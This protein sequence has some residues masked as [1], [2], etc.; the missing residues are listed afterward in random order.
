MSLQKYYKELKNKLYLEGAFSF[1]NFTLLNGIFLIGFALALGA[2]NLQIGILVAIPLFANLLQ[3]V[4][5]FIL[6]RTGTK[7]YTTLISLFFGRVL[8]VIIIL[9]AFGFISKGNIIYTIMAVLLLSSAFNSIGNLSLLSWMKDIVP[10]R[11]LASFWGKRSIYATASGILVYLIGSYILD[12]YKFPEIYGYIFLFALIIGMAG[13]IYLMRIPDD[14]QKIKAINPKKFFRRLNIPLKD[15]N[16][17]PL[18]HFGLFWG[19][20]INVA[21]PFFLVYMIDDLSLSF[22]VI[23]I[24]LVIDALARIYGLNIW[25]K[26]ADSFGARPI[27][28]VC[29]TITSTLPLAFMFINKGNY[30]LIVPLFIISAISYS[31]V[32][33]AITQILFKSAPRRYDAYYLSTFTS[34]TGLTSSIGPVIG[35]ILAFIIKNN[36]ELP[37]MHFFSPLKYVFLASFILRAMAV[38]LILRIHEPKARDV[39]DI[40]ERMKTLRFVSLFVNIYSFADYTSK[41]VLIPQKQFFILQRATAERA[42]KDLSEVKDI[43]SKALVVLSKVYI[44]SLSGYK[45]KIIRLRNL[46]SSRMDKLD[47]IKGG[48]LKEIPKEII[49]KMES[50]ESSIESKTKEVINKEIKSVEA[51]IKKDQKILEQ[52]HSGS[53]SKAVK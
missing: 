22:F 3:L 27:L 41:I 35:G 2:N 51:F 9:V 11:K 42:K 19:F 44:S 13:L 34:L 39:K 31:A 18:L 46:L 47:Y 48:E 17:K 52:A 10:L 23:S 40:I 8:W 29:A 26:I 36:S 14:P 5:A 15:A 32:D 50:L 53:D 1:A 4:S 20:A 33:I 24:F 49:S 16:F 25:R 7:K 21:S 38:P 37:F 6:E 43:I 12:H 45:S 30:I 28:T